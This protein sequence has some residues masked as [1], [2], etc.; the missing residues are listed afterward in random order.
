LLKNVEEVLN[1]F[2]SKRAVFLGLYIVETGQTVR[3]TA[4][5]YGLSKSTVH[6]DVSNRLKSIDFSLYK[7]VKIV[8]EKNF[9]EKH[10]R[11]GETTR[12]KYLKK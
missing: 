9:L 6:N 10:I 1:N 12:K 7:R 4:G 3:Q 11:G 8:L 2:L 5:F